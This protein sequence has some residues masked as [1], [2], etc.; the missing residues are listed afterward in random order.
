MNRQQKAI[1]V[2]ELKKSLLGSKAAFLVGFRG[3][4]VSQ[5]QGLRSDL[6]SKGG[7]LKVA[8]A[9]L[10]KRAV[11]GETDIEQLAPFFKDQ[12]GIVFA[13]EQF[14]DVAKILS[15]FSK[16]NE[17]LNL[18]AGYLEATVIDKGRI[19]Q[20]AS[21]PPKEVLLA[22]VCGTLNAPIVGMVRS[23]NMIILKLLFVLKQVGEKKK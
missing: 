1:V 5:M 19:S 2:E 3:L 15:D 20:I 13:Q 10:M 6:R 22:Q 17:A 14:S 21:L 7:S 23:L 18:V 9:R 12:I 16:K 4:N 8:K 11:D